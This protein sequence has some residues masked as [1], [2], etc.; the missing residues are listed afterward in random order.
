MRSMSRAVKTR[1]EFR[2]RGTSATFPARSHRLRVIGA[3]PTRPA[4][5]VSLKIRVMRLIR[6]NPYQ[7]VSMLFSQESLATTTLCS[8]AQGRRSGTQ[9]AWERELVRISRRKG[10]KAAFAALTCSR[11]FS[12]DIALSRACSRASRWIDSTS[13]D[14]FGRIAN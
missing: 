8:A 3:T 11:S 6:I 10:A 7:V 9:A 13:G 2:S 14:P 4:A 5:S 12:R 1:Q